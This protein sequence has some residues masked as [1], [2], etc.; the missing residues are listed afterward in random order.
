MWDFCFETI[1]KARKNYDCQ[2]CE[3]VINCLDISDLTDEEIKLYETAKSE[4][5]K[6]LKGQEYLKI[7]GK[8]EG[9]FSVF[10]ARPEIEK[11]CQKYNLYES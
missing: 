6:V 4:G 11:L 1:Q 3:W 10:R 5:F 9:D 8:W 2:A 7:S